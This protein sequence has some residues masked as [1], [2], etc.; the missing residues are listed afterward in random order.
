MKF[1]GK[2][3]KKIEYLY[4]AGPISTGQLIQNVR[5]MCY[6][7]D[8]LMNYKLAPYNPASSHTQDL[9]LPRSYSDWLK[10]D[11]KM[12][13]KMGLLLRMPGDSKGADMEIIWAKQHGIPIII[14]E[15]RSDL[16]KFCRRYGIT[17]KRK[18]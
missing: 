7:A 1:I 17:P 5:E 9:I 18:R 13:T 15:S 8:M 11:F 10:Y 4:L 6:Y 16:L 12:L 2:I 14:L 3:P